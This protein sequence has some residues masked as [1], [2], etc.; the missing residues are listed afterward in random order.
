[1]K[2][3]TIDIGN[4]PLFIFYEIKYRIISIEW[5]FKSKAKQLLEVNSEKRLIFGFF[6]I[7]KI[8][9]VGYNILALERLYNSAIHI[10]YL[11]YYLK[12]LVYYIK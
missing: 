5:K 12:A 3:S 4:L 2:S 9:D 11:G 7:I 1:M 10:V 8:C 6:T